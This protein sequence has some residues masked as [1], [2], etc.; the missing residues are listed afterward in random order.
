MTV[1]SEDANRRG[2][3]L[4]R[5][6]FVKVSATA[7]TA[8]AIWPAP[9]VH[10][11][12]SETIRL[13]LIG[14]G[15]RGTGAVSQALNADPGVTLV[16]MA[17]VFED[18]LSASL[19]RVTKHAPQRVQVDPEARFVGFDAYR[20]VIELADVVI[21]ATPPQFRPMHLEAA[22]EAG[23][24]VF[25]EKPVAVDAPGVR[26]VLETTEAAREKNVSIVSGFCWR[27]SAPERAT[28]A[29][30]HEGA[31]GEIVSMETTYLASPL[32][33]YARKPGCSDMACSF[34]TGGISAGSPATT[35]SS[36]PATALT[37]STGP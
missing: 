28:Y 21:L 35:S 22:V 8:G 33:T 7:A 34:A 13:G 17:D 31:I 15:G 2:A 36:R 14:C 12:G 24:H 32:N 27:Y 1:Q 11:G 37:R 25:C 29:R 19:E 20:H 4:T 16:A 6:E 10:A 30:I 9:F 18:R 26:S 3:G 23:K 5:R